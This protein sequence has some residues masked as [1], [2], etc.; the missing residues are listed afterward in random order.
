LYF[1]DPR[2]KNKGGAEC[3]SETQ[4][5]KIREEQKKEEVRQ[6]ERE[7]ERREKGRGGGGGGR[8]H[9]PSRVSLEF[10]FPS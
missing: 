6:R 7:E 4:E 10:F 8:R 3:I 5:E 2:R 1:R 9:L